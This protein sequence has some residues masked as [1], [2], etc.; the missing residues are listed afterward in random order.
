MKVERWE[1]W[2][3]RSLA[4]ATVSI[5][6]PSAVRR[7]YGPVPTERRSSRS[8]RRLRLLRKRGKQWRFNGITWPGDNDYTAAVI[9]R[10]SLPLLAAFEWTTNRDTLFVFPPE[11]PKS[12]LSGFLFCQAKKNTTRNLKQKSETRRLQKSEKK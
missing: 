7:R 5:P 2:C 3:E 8:S 9:T 4:M 10:P 12:L 11:I 6:W 1:S